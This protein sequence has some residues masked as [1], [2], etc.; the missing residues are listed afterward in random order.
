MIPIEF[1]RQSNDDR[2]TLVIE[3]SARPMRS[4]WALMESERLEDA[5]ERL[6]VREGK[7]KKKHIGYWTR[8]SLSPDSIPALKEWAQGKDIDSVIWTALPPR[9]NKVERVPSVE[10]I[11]SHLRQLSGT[12]R[13]QAEQ[14]VRLAPPQIDTDNRRR[15]EAEFLW[16]PPNRK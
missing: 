8:G 11:L 10:E 1:S 7:P 12:V 6:R 3:P 16:F 9:I 5:R 4:L 2:I 14:Y 13:D 15:I